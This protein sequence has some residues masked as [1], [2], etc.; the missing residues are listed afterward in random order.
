MWLGSAG[1]NPSQFTDIVNI[2]DPQSWTSAINTGISLAF[3]AKLA[4]TD[5]GI[6]ALSKAR[7][8]VELWDCNNLLE[9]PEGWLAT[10]PA[11]G[12]ENI[13]LTDL[14]AIKHV[15]EKLVHSSRNKVAILAI[16][17]PASDIIDKSSID[18]VARAIREAHRSDKP[19]AEALMNRD[20]RSASSMLDL[21]MLPW[22]GDLLT[23]MKMYW[24]LYDLQIVAS[25]IAQ[26]LKNVNFKNLRKPEDKIH[27]NNHNFA[28]ISKLS[29]IAPFVELAHEK[30]KSGKLDKRLI[31][32]LI[33]KAKGAEQEEFFVSIARSSGFNISSLKE[34][35]GI[36]IPSGTFSDDSIRN[37]INDAHKWLKFTESNF[38]PKIYADDPQSSEVTRTIKIKNVTRAAARNG[39]P[40]L[41]TLARGILEFIDLTFTI[42]SESNRQSPIQRYRSKQNYETRVVESA[43]RVAIFN[44][45]LHAYRAL[46][47]GDRFSA[48]KGIGPTLPETS[49]SN[50]YINYLGYNP[51]EAE[52]LIYKA[53]DNKGRDA[54][55]QANK[56]RKAKDYV[57]LLQ[58]DERVFE[59]FDEV[60][61][62]RRNQAK[63]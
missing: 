18:D 37:M 45:L 56:A 31:R 33:S 7:Y 16:L 59:A 55:I 26:D 17:Q 62:L 24:R 48:E 8:D 49:D 29:K 51:G 25:S 42:R 47:I 60:S 10:N 30:Q 52:R 14:N 43:S 36:E 21:G 20:L 19:F 1:A 35:A 15:L 53:S 32:D 38:I 41:V 2:R 13:D 11:F 22:C 44:N 57:P 50:R 27:T 3:W 9:C 58:S 39:E 12:P 61:A 6:A 54:K 5:E 34:A 4:T 46:F 28:Y 63:A 40:A 23:R